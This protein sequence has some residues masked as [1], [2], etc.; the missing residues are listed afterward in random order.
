MEKEERQVSI[1]LNGQLYSIPVSL[2]SV[3]KDLEKPK[4]NSQ[5]KDSKDTSK[6]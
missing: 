1:V 4:E 2:V 6:Q 3:L 5:E